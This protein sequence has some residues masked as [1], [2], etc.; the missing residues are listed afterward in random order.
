[1]NLLNLFD[2]VSERGSDE[3]RSG[4]A[5]VYAHTAEIG[6]T[7]ISIFNI[8]S[9]RLIE[10]KKKENITWVGLVIAIAG[11][12]TS[13]YL[14]AG[15]GV[16]MIIVGVSFAIWNYRRKLEIYLSIGTSDGRST[17]IVSKDRSFLVEVRKFFLEKIDTRNENTAVI[18]ISNSRL[19][20]V[21][22]IGAN[23]NAERKECVTQEM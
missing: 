10:L 9:I 21:I 15:L 17:V 19:E 20:G 2:L 13:F 8:G 23:S 16:I 14:S 7:V 12:L 3:V 11:I 6:D 4:Q 5:K 22:A 1:M 18:N